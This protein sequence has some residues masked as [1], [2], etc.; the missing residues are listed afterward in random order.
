M[1]AL[2]EEEV[3]FLYNEGS[4]S[5]SRSVAATNGPDLCSVSKYPS[6][7]ERGLKF[8]KGFVGCVE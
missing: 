6:A 7:M 5:L 8:V 4:L 2:K 1:T 3:F